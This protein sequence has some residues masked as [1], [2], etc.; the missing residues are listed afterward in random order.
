MRGGTGGGTE[1]DSQEPAHPHPC[2]LS[3]ARRGQDRPRAIMYV[4]LGFLTAQGLLG[5]K[6]V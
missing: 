6:A 5:F 3:F 2:F 1:L 4:N